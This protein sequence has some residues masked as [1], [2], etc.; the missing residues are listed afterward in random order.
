[1]ANSLLTNGSTKFS[2]LPS[3]AESCVETA[4]TVQAFLDDQ[5]SSDPTSLASFPKGDEALEKARAK[6]RNDAKALYDLATGP[7]EI[8]MENSLLSVRP[9]ILQRAELRADSLIAAMGQCHEI[10]HPL[11]DPGL[12]P[13]D[14]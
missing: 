13:R 11:Q 8:L 6:L 7:H 10:H 12:H 9:S 3:L 14:G 2:T 1:M 4:K 5:G